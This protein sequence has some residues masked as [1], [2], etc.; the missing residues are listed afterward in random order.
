MKYFLIACLIISSLGCTKVKE[1][2][3]ESLEDDKVTGRFEIIES[4]Y[5]LDSYKNT[6]DRGSIIQDR[7]TKVCYLSLWSGMGNGGPALAQIACPN[8][9][10]KE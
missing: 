5:M 7:Q 6:A 8:K 2:I 10:N 4:F 3:V 1:K 9:E